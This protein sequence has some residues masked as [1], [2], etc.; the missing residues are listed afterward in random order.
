MRAHLQEEDAER[1]NRKGYTKHTPALPLFTSDDASRAMTLLQPVGYD[2]PGPG[3]SGRVSAE[4]VNAGHLLGSALRAHAR[5]RRPDK[6]HAVRRRPRA[7]RP[8]R[9][10]RSH[11]DRRRRT[12]CSS[13]PP[14]AIG[15]TR[16]TTTARAWPT[17][18][19]DDR[20]TR[21]QGH[22]A[23]VRARPRRG[24]AVLDRTARDERRIPELPVYVDS[25]MATRRAAAYRSR[26]RRSWIPRSSTPWRARRRRAGDAETCARSARRS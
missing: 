18:I 8:A 17:I 21:R 6:T 1:A 16:P 13:S 25:P 24:T 15:C 7:L 9:A 11:A 14:T 22:H 20:A 3:G 5:G 12:C 26:A 23:G 19:N 4:F 10:A 2:R